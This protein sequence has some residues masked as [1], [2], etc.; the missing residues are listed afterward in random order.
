MTKT[1]ITFSHDFQ[2]IEYVNQVVHS[3][4]QGAQSFQLKTSGS[5]GIP[6]PLTLSRKLL[7]WSVKGTKASLRLDDHQKI[8]CCLPIRKT[9]G[10]MQLIRALYLEWDIHFINPSANPLKGINGGQFTLTSFTPMQ[11]ENSLEHEEV[12]RSISNVLV[13]GAPVHPELVLKL[14]SLPN[15]YWETYGMTETASHIALRQIGRDSE[16][17]PMQG[18][19]VNTKDNRLKIGIESLGIALLTNDIALIDKE[20]NFKI[21]GRVDDIINSGGLKIYPI[22]LESKIQSILTEAGFTATFYVSHLPDQLL[23]QKVILIM[24][25]S[26]EIDRKILLSTLKATLDKPYIPKGIYW[27]EHI[28]RTDTDKL[29]RRPLD[30]YDKY[31]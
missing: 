13:G 19:Q 26:E 12:L 23:G 9:G 28:L 6:K 30:A 14:V 22:E 29:I 25:Q 8:L 1:G 31:S 16:F 17:I 18:V 2:D 11:L 4:E 21:F 20:G 15:T 24:E 27:V 3:W 5:T 10:F 7:V